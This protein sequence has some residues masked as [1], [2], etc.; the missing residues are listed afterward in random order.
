MTRTPAPVTDRTALH[1][2]LYAFAGLGIWGAI[3]LYFKAVS[4]VP[5]LEVLAH[6]VVWS[7][8][9]TGLLL[10]VLRSWPVVRAV[11]RERRA[12]LVLAAS[13]LAIAVN[14]LVF[15][16]AVGNDRVLHASL[17]Y[18]INPLVS[19]LFGMALLRERLT[20]WQWAAVI[21]AAAGVGNMVF[22]LD[23]FPWVS[24][25]VATSFAIY[26]LLR[27]LVQVEAVAGLFVETLIAAPLALGYLVAVAVA[28]DGAMGSRGLPFDALLAASGL[29][30]AVPLICFVQA[31]LRLRLSTLGLL[32]YITPT[33]QFLCAV[34]VFGERFTFVHAITFGFIWT[35]L[36]VYSIDTLGRQRRIEEAT[37]GT[38]S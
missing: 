6:R 21:L 38:V 1:G 4:S 15:I 25:T 2:V 28:G 12:M 26:G 31:A 23:V 30:T 9:V 13:T 37:D 29:A 16:W 32:Q 14:W 20:R 11:A 35:A 8:L 18:Y 17:G 19:V 34:L 33:G 10:T 3:P 22:R 36:V 27:K 24:L 5:P 7:V